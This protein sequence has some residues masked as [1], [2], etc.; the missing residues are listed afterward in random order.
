MQHDTTDPIAQQAAELTAYD[1]QLIVAF[2]ALAGLAAMALAVR[3][4]EYRDWPHLI[5]IAFLGSV[6]GFGVVGCVG[7]ACGGV[8]GFELLLLC[9]ASGAGLGGRLLERA[10]TSKTA[11]MLGVELDH[12]CRN[13]DAGN[14]GDVDSIEPSES[15]AAT[16]DGSSRDVDA[17]D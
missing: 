8:I 6:V 15:A 16:G 12:V 9:V 14:G 2:A 4:G 7:H 13:D 1:W 5:S 10:I 11:A 17:G 3:D